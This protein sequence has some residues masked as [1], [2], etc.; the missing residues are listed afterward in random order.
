[1]RDNVILSTTLNNC[2]YAVWGGEK[3]ECV[4]ILM[5]THLSTDQTLTVNI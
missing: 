3:R 1:M 4:R 2:V 5:R